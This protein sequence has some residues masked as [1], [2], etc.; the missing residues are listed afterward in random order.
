MAQE[1][2]S[3]MLDTLQSDL[4][5]LRSVFGYGAGSGAMP[6]QIATAHPTH[7]KRRR[8]ASHASKVAATT[9]ATPIAGAPVK[10]KLTKAARTK[11]SEAAKARW[12]QR[13]TGTTAPQKAA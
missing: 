11:L 10:R 12:A 3:G 9:S 8:M 6:A 1:S 5:R 2:I 4:N 13:K 7:T